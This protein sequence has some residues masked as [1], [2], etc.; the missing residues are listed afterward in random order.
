MNLQSLFGLFALAGIGWLLSERRRGVRLKPLAAGLL[1][2]VAL[3]LLLLKVPPVREGFLALNRLVMSLEEAT[4]AGTSLVF[5]YLGGG[6]LPFAEPHPGAAYVLAF[7]GLPMVLVVG[8]LSSLLFHWRILP[9][10]VRGMAWLLE[11]S[12]GVGGALGVGAAANIF[13]GMTEAPLLVRP[14]LAKLNRSELFALMTCGMATIAGTMMVL[15]AAILGPVIPDAL[16]HILIASLIS[17]PAAITAARLLVPEEGPPTPGGIAPERQTSSAMDAIT[18]GT[19]TGLQLLL[20]IVAMLI[21]LVA[22]VHLANLL[23]GLLPAVAGA[24]LSLERMLGWAMAPVAWL[25]G[26]PWAEAQTAGT[27]M[28]VKTV[29]NEF[30]AYLQLAGLDAEAL[31]PRSRLIM[32]YAM[33]GFANFGSLGI[34]IGGMGTM[35]PERRG[36]IVA[37]G[38][39]SIVA[40]T[41]ATC[42]TGAVVG[43]LI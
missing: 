40:G 7:R 18:Q 10:V 31:S 23:L 1:L 12:M 34:M 39:K 16:G 9:W 43:M 36:E 25:M 27:L 28:G 17:A 2:Q 37:L 38:M 5:G 24:P 11:R 22:L 20:N 21:V 29:L 19:L 6:D 32:T 4:Q 15:Y 42:M 3:A 33:C 41:L 26:V 8:A 14:Y 30:V 35:V 13:V